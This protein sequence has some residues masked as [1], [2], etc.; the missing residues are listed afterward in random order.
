VPQQ[1]PLDIYRGD[2]GHWRFTLYTDAGLTDPYDLTG[3]SAEAEV[4]LKTNTTVLAAMDCVITLPN[5]IDVDLSAEDSGNLSGKA[6]WDLQLTW[7]SGGL[8]KTVVA[9]P[10]TVTDDVTDSTRP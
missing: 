6:V 8:V 1:V 10:V 2:S 3:A 9:G 4:R 7:A 5:I